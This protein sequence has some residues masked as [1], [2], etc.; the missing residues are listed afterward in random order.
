MTLTQA[1]IET[2]RS[3]GGYATLGHLYRESLKVP[4]VEWKTKTPFKSINRVVQESNL[5]YKIKPGLWALKE[6]KTSLANEPAVST[7]PESDHYYYQGLLVELGNMQGFQSFVPRPDRGKRYLNGTLGS[8]ATL[9]EIYPFTYPEIVKQA[10]MVDVIWFGSN[11]NKL[12]FPAEF[13]EVE[14]TTNFNASLVKFTEFQPFNSKFKIVAPESKHQQFKN[15][16]QQRAF[17]PLKEIVKFISYDAV[18]ELHSKLSALQASRSL[19]A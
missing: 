18:S 14:N 9:E 19:W 8:V 3:N 10:G 1:V 17:E 16:M 6:S 11:K 5:I 2:M 13:I 12:N 4:G 15:R 7:K